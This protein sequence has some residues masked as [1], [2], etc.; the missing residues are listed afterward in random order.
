M[1]SFLVGFL[2][3]MIRQGGVK[4]PVLCCI[5]MVALLKKGLK[6]KVLGAGL[7]TIYFGSVGYAD[8]LKLL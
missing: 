4:C 1:G 3:A 2:P 6:Q 5:Y 7:I 8:D